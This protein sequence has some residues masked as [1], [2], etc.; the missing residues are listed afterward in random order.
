MLQAPKTNLASSALGEG[1]RLAE[2][3]VNYYAEKGGYNYSIARCFSF[4]GPYLPLDIHYAIGNFINDALTK[5]EIIVKGGGNE[6]R[7][8][9]Y[10]A[11]AWVWLLKSLIH[12]DNQIYNV[13]SS[14]AI[15][16][17]DLAVLVRDCLAPG[18]TVKTLG[19]SHDVGNFS[20]NLYLPNTDKIQK[21]LDLSE[22]TPLANGIYKMARK[23]R[24]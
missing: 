16:I 8:Y 13:G 17:G 4:F 15:S 18:K 2:Y 23:L 24:N 20:R 5:E 22:W 10:I 12:T 6:L 9:L 1:K 11:D 21:M 14:N 3:L 7:S 19:K